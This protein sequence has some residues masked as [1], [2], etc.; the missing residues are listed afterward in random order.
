MQSYV[1]AV[2]WG[3]AE[4]LLSLRKYKG[5]KYI[6]SQKGIMIKGESSYPNASVAPSPGVESPGVET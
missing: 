4:V 6:T 3:V 2:V 1:V 5:A